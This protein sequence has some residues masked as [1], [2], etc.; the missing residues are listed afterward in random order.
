MYNISK[1]SKDIDLKNILPIVLKENIFEDNALKTKINDI[2]YLCIDDLDVIWHSYD[3]H[4]LR[5]LK[6][7]FKHI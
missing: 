6:S 4:N 5:H 7:F 1:K 3:N 2:L